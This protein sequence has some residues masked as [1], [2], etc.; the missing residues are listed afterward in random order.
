MLDGRMQ[1]RKE[2]KGNLEARPCH[3]KVNLVK[4]PKGHA[5]LVATTGRRLERS[6]REVALGF[7]HERGRQWDQGL[8]GSKNN[9]NNKNSKQK[10]NKQNLASTGSQ[11]PI[12]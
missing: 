1:S 8:I 2:E 5:Q 12:F 6:F 7:I 11:G 10:T 9:N 3:P 4:S